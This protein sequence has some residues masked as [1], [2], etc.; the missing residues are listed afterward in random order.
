MV[1]IS[2]STIEP[3]MSFVLQPW[4]LLLVALASWVNRQQ[5]M[6][7]QFQDEEIR[8]LLERQG[9]K[10]L[11]LTDD[12]RRRLAVKGKVLGRKAL[13]ELTT[14]VTPDTILRWHRELIAQKW[15][16]S[17]RRKKK[18]GRPAVS[19]EITGLVLRMA[20]EN[21]DWGYDRIQGALANLGHKISDQTVGNILKAHGLEPAPERKRH[22]TWKTFLKAHWDVLG[23]IDFTT[24]EVWT[25][26]GLVTFY[27]LFVSVLPSSSSLV[28]IC[29]GRRSTNSW[30][31]TTVKETTKVWPIRSS[32]PVTRLAAPK[33]MCNAMN[34]LAACFGTITGMQ[35]EQCTMFHWLKTR[36]IE[37]V[38][39]YQQE[40]IERL[41]RAA[42]RLKD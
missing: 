39:R 9:K 15:D 19:Q 5:Q 16:Y 4:Q 6:I 36:L 21:P 35:R 25:K 28:R 7:I 18:P 14:I 2:S 30:P 33:A 1:E 40:K 34:V 42:L 37:G 17:D 3:T 31:T 20:R 11:L 24:V 23:S 8:S 41:H 12:Q 26:G 32:N 27:L 29:C 22:T 38:E 10:R 13:S